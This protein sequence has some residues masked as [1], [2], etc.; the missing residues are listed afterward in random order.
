MRK[1][2]TAHSLEDLLH[3]VRGG[4]DLRAASHWDLGSE[5]A[6]SAASVLLVM[7]WECNKDE[8][9]GLHAQKISFL[10]PGQMGW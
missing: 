6:L 3:K 5:L 1:G 8:V 9:H 2:V 10:L 4:P 7:S